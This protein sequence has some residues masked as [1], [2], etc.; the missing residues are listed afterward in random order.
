VP[1]SSTGSGTPQGNAGDPTSG[2]DANL[3]PY[4]D[5]L[6]QYAATAQSEVDRELIPADDQQLVRE[7][8]QNLAS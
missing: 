7:Y 3:V 1:G 4:S 8:F 5:Y 2:S 6:A